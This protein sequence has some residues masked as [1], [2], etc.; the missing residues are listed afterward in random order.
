MVTTIDRPLVR[1][2]TRARVPKG[3]VR[4]AAVSARGSNAAPL[5]VRWPRR[6]API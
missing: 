3:R 2:V 5:A 1:Q 4:C 6:L